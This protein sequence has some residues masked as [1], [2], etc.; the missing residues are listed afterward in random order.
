MKV[1]SNIQH[2]CKLLLKNGYSIV[3]GGTDNHLLLADMRS[4]GVDGAR[5]E[6]LL[7]ELCIYITEKEKKKTTL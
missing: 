5:M 6:L 7:N 4:K 2:M 1:L 3:S